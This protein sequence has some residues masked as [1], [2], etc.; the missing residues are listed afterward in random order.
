MKKFFLLFLV[1][2]SFTISYA[3]YTYLGNYFTW[4][5]YQATEQTEDDAYVAPSNKLVGKKWYKID[6]GPDDI[7]LIF[8][9]NGTGSQ[10]EQ[11][12]SYK[13]GDQPLVFKCTVPFQWKRK[14]L[15]L[16]ITR[17][18][19]SVTYQITQSSSAQYSLRKQDEIKQYIAN[20]KENVKKKG[21]STVTYKILK[22]TDDI[23]R[24]RSWNFVTQSKAEELLKRK[25]DEERQRR[26]LNSQY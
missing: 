6:N 23:L 16:T 1:L 2:H 13:F 10:I 20:L 17:L 11:F 9:Q 19:G 26:E 4:E 15:D 3:Q 18:W 5:E 22:F 24:T 25:S 7:C 8:N 14:G 12:D 21:S